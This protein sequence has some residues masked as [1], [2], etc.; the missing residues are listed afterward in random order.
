MAGFKVGFIMFGI[1]HCRS[2][3][4]GSLKKSVWV[5]RPQK[6]ANIENVEDG[7]AIIGWKGK[8]GGVEVEA[9]V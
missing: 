3:F 7:K 5:A 2:A 6:R 1:I 8:R 4:P 9:K